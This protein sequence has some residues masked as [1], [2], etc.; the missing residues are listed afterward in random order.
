MAIRFKKYIDITSGVGGVAAV[1]ARELI[2]RLFTQN[3][4]VPTD[5]VLEFD[6][7]DEVMAYF[8]SAS[9][10]YKAALFYFG[11]ISKN[12][13]RAKK[14]SFAFWAEAATAPRIYGASK[15]QTLANY[16]AISNGS[17]KLTLG[18]DTFDIT[19]M[20]FNAAVSLTDVATILQT[21]IRAADVA[22][23]WAN[24]TVTYDAT[25]KRFNLVGGATGEAAVAVAVTG[26]GT[27]VAGLLGWLVG[28]ILSPGADAQTADECVSAS[29]DGS[30]NFGSFAFL[31]ELDADQVLAVAQWNHAEN[32]MFMFLVPA[33]DDAEATAFFAA[34]GL[35]SGVAVTLQETAG[36]YAHI[37]PGII[38]AAT[39]YTRRNSVQNYMYQQFAISAPVA[40]TPRSNALDAV[41]CNYNGQTQQ[42]GQKL[43]FYQRGSMM[44]GNTAPVAMNVYANEIWLKDGMG[45]ELLSLLLALARVSA[46]SRGRSQVRSTLQTVID[47]ALD[48][49]TISVGKPLNNTQ[50]LYIAEVTGS[51]TAW[52]QVQNAG[53]W[54]DCE[55][56]SEVVN[57]VIEWKAVYVLIYSK[58]DA[59]RKIEG[60]HILI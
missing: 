40:D 52:H 13:T 38:L 12:I 20:D 17:L 33:A 45:V 36:E 57:S 25:A 6:D 24:A 28:P 54:V 41:R 44:G 18:G 19:G 30:N 53:Y 5:G 58:D 21:A 8:G 16:Q 29:A 56:S 15:T 26:S 35:L 49:G 34:L 31:D 4:L 10:E 27:D 14:I 59:I 43:A 3:P 9:D 51:E 23:L 39:D 37:I 32:V 7:A 50:K 47:R 11:W 46:N 22:A 2:L 48:N 55:I 60:T 42:A 1:A